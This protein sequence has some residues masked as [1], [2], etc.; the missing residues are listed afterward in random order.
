MVSGRLA[1]QQIC[2]RSAPQTALLIQHQE[3]VVDQL[4]TPQNLPANQ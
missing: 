3:P 1:S 4:T 2:P